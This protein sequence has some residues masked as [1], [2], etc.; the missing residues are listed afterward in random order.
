MRD[1]ELFQEAFAKRRRHLESTGLWPDRVLR[2][3]PP[4]ECLGDRHRAGLPVG[5]PGMT[6]YGASEGDLYELYAQRKQRLAAERHQRAAMA[7][8]PPAE[9]APEPRKSAPR[10]RIGWKRRVNHAPA[11]AST[12]P[13]AARAHASKRSRPNRT[14]YTA[15]T[16]PRPRQGQGEGYRIKILKRDGMC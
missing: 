8:P 14:P 16:H 6:S 15:R 7:A 9:P 10:R 11:S 3:E 2:R 13:R 5:R 4:V 1:H 12:R